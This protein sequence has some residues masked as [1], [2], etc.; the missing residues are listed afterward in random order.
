MEERV[1]S[2]LPPRQ[3]RGQDNH[4]HHRDAHPKEVVVVELVSPRRPGKQKKP[5]RSHE[6]DAEALDRAKTDPE[7]TLTAG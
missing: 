6:P 3:E 4:D 5:Q 1:S 7:Q 2:V